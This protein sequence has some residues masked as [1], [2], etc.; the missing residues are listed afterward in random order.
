MPNIITVSYFIAIILFI[1]GLKGMSSPVTAKRGIIW[2]GLGMFLATVATLADPEIAHIPL[3]LI[4]IL[5]GGGLALYAGKKVKITDMPQM[6]ALFNGLGGGSAA[7]ISAIELLRATTT[8]SDTLMIITI[9]GA[10]IGSISFSGSLIAFLKLQG[11]M[12]KAWRFYQQKLVNA[13]IFIGMITLAVYVVL[14]PNNL[15][16]LSSLFAISLLLGVA[17]TVPIGGA[18]MPVIISLYNALTGLAVAAEGFALQNP[19]MIIAGTIVGSA[20]T[21]LTQLMARAMNRS[22]ANILFSNF[23]E[24]ASGSGETTGEMKPMEIN[25]AASMLA[26]ASKI[27]IVPG[28]GMAVAQAQHKVWE[29]AKLLLEKNIT[30]KFAIHPV[31]GRMPGHMNVLLAEAGV[32]YDL[33]FDLEEIND[34]FATT[35]VAIVIGANDVVNPDARNKKDSP[36]YGMPILNVDKAKDIFAVKRGEG[37][38]FSGVQNPLFFLDNTHMLFG[39]AQ[40][41]VS[42]LIQTVKQF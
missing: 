10:L 30:V 19:A 25:D 38:G 35:D 8:N 20:G 28:Y 21:L 9:V 18:D 36:I 27:V 29:L 14:V 26:Y 33:I 42:K 17:I 12:K 37:T 34:E 13:L 24:T 41:V 3:M 32:P 7:T 15:W 23:G 5:I 31:A 4:A 39:D 2:A 11:W 16:L 1:F 40:G 6:I 22:M